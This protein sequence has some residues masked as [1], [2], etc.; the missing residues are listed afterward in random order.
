MK[1]LLILYLSVATLVTLCVTAI[2]KL[3]R[4]RLTAVEALVLAISILLWPV[5]VLQWSVSRAL[6]KLKNKKTDVG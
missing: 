4:M 6:N 3:G 2:P 5:L 1:T